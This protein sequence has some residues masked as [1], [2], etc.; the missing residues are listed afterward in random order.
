MA[1]KDAHQLIEHGLRQAR[2]ESTSRLALVQTQA[3]QIAALSAE[4][5]GLQRQLDAQEKLVA[6]KESALKKA[7]DSLAAAQKRADARSKA[8]S[9]AADLGEAYYGRLRR[10]AEG[11]PG[12][13][14]GATKNLV[15]RDPDA[16]ASGTD[17]DE[18]Q[19]GT[20]KCDAAD[21]SAGGEGTEKAASNRSAAAVGTTKLISLKSF[22]GP[23][24]KSDSAPSSRGAGTPRAKAQ[25]QNATAVAPAKTSLTPK[26]KADAAATKSVGRKRVKLDPD[27]S[28][29]DVVPPKKSAKRPS[30][31]DV[32]SGSDSDDDV[33]P[34]QKSPKKPSYVDM[35]SEESDSDGRRFPMQLIRTFASADADLD[36]VGVWSSSAIT[37]TSTRAPP[38]TVI[39]HPPHFFF[40]P[41]P[42]GDAMAMG[43]V[44]VW[45]EATEKVVG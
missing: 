42:T 38:V 18:P 7:E 13:E 14:N 2:E 9:D 45:A 21:T 40:L 33:V 31:V 19:H 4:R 25:S 36:A 23:T 39:S 10:L 27:F 37:T 12:N 20:A 11:L 6:E 28:D 41:P 30:Y 17:E 29:D 1:A 34:P 22:F 44:S 16:S 3:Q 15:K 35:D 26:R 5:D 43:A 32:D 8:V 24:A